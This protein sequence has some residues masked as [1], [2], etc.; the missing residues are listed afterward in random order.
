MGVTSYI[1]INLLKEHD[2]DLYSIKENLSLK[3]IILPSFNKYLNDKTN[4]ET[5][6]E[7][8]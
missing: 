1:F 7:Y 6:L 2:V 3:D 8:E 5:E 4:D